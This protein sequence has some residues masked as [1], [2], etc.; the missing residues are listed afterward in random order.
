MCCSLFHFIIDLRLQPYSLCVYFFVP[1]NI[2]IC[3]LVYSRINF[4]NVYFIQ[5]PKHHYNFLNSCFGICAVVSSKSKELTL[6]RYLSLSIMRNKCTCIV[7]HEYPC[8]FL[9]LLTET[10]VMTFA[11]VLVSFSFFEPRGHLLY[12]FASVSFFD[13]VN[14]IFELIRCFVASHFRPQQY[15]QY[16]TFKW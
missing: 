4:L 6:W 10:A 1:H 3:C 13:P 7:W 9:C 5:H 14:S 11:C 2:H 12:L 16:K 8:M 15:H